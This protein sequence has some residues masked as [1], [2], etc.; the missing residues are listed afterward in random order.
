M[1]SE[2]AAK[3]L[4]IKKRMQT[5]KQKSP[6]QKLFSKKIALALSAI[7]TLEKNPS[8]VHLYNLDPTASV[9]FLLLPSSCF[10]YLGFFSFLQLVLSDL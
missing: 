4:N 8:F 5:N 6:N 7:L 3:S 2:G 1:L 10:S 9:S